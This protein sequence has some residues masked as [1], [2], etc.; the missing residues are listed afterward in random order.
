[1]RGQSSLFRLLVLEKGDVGEV[2]EVGEVDVD[3]DEELRWRKGDSEDR[4]RDRPRCLSGGEETEELVGS[5]GWVGVD[6]DVVRGVVM[7][8]SGMFIS[9]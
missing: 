7:R 6:G 9:V 2:G 8:G 5:D 4:V 3:A 1:M